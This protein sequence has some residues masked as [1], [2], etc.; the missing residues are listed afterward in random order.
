MSKPR[1]ITQEELDAIQQSV[2]IARKKLEVERPSKRS[3]DD[4]LLGH[5][6][7]C[8]GYEDWDSMKAES[9]GLFK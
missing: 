4:R 1:P 5:A 9:P 3:R 2:A 6:L 7:C 8:W